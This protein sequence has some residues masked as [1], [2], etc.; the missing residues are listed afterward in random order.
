MKFLFGSFLVILSISFGCAKRPVVKPPDTPPPPGVETKTEPDI[1]VEWESIPELNMIHFDYDK[2]QIRSDAREVLKKNAE[3]LKKNPDI[4]ILIEGHCDER[5]TTEYNL[6]LGQRR[7]QAVREYYS[8]LGIPLGSIAT[9]SYGE[10]KPL[11]FQSTEE[12]WAKN[13][14]AE[15]KVKRQ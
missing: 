8:R 13:R 6:A 10:E 1:R 9:I 11:D 12:A 3:Y 5:G 7:A 4:N 2:S 14:R 15:T